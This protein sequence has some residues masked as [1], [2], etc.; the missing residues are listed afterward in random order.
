MDGDL[1]AFL[2]PTNTN[3]ENGDASGAK[4]LRKK[5]RKQAPVA[6]FQVHTVDLTQDEEGDMHM[7]AT[8]QVDADAE[9][10]EPVLKK[11][12]LEEPAP[13]VVDEF[14][15]EAKREVAADAG[16]TGGDVSGTSILLT[17]QVSIHSSYRGFDL[18]R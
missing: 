3:G 4:K 8:G 13:V 11:V 9:G 2:D 14:E 16:L 7:D 15:T 1:F 5:K 17:H 6:E 18:K 12:R 10:V